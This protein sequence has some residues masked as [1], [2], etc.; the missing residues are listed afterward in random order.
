MGTHDKKARHVTS[1]QLVTLVTTVEKQTS[2]RRTLAIFS[3]LKLMIDKREKKA[4]ND[5]ISRYQ[6]TKELKQRPQRQRQ[7]EWEKKDWSTLAEQQICKTK[8]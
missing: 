2:D 7:Q 6:D 5:L 8:T 4:N 3:F 1:A